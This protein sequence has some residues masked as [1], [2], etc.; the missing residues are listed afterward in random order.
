VDGLV[1]ENAGNGGNL[2]VN[3]RIKQLERPGLLPQQIVSLGEMGEGD[4][5]NE[6]DWISASR[7]IV[8]E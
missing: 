5:A 2:S 3:K 1:Q 8:H 7:K 6:R 4:A